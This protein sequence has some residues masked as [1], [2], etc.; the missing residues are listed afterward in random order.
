[1]DTP[2]RHQEATHHEIAGK[3]ERRTLTVEEAARA[4]GIGRSAGYAAARNGELPTVKIGRRLLVPRD[5]L[6]RML[7]GEGQA[8]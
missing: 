8:A 3:V 4:L 6:D 7:A 2:D 1:M 5:A